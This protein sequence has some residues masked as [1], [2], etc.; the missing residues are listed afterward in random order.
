VTVVHDD[1]DVRVSV[2]DEGPGI[3]RADQEEIFDRFTRLA[4]AAGVPGSGLGLFIARSIAESQGGR[5]EV[6]SAPGEGATFEL[7]LPCAEPAP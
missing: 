2:A 1:H 3:A 4:T 5:L 7:T 6:H